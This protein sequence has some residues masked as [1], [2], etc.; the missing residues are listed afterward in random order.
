MT[1]PAGP[2]TPGRALPT[3]AAGFSS[4][5]F[6]IS[7]HSTLSIS[8]RGKN[9]MRHR[10]LWCA[11]LLGVLLVAGLLSCG[12]GEKTAD[13]QQTDQTST[14]GGKAAGGQGAAG[15]QAGAITAENA[16]FAPAIT[17]KG[18]RIVQ[19]RRF[20]SQVDARR[21]SVVVYRAADGSRGGV[22]YVRSFGGE[23]PQPVWHWFF[24]DGAPDSVQ[25]ADINHDGLW[26]VRVFMSGG[27][28]VDYLQDEAFTF[29]GRERDGL[30]AMNGESSA[31]TDMWKAFDADT[32]TAWQS[33]APGAF[34]EVPNP[35]GLETGE[36]S[37]QLSGRDRPKKVA[38][39]AGDRKAQEF[40]L[41]ATE[42]EQRF[43]LDPSLRSAE[44]I[45]VVL[46]G[47][48]GSVAISEME[49]R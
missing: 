41:A 34:L 47:A 36:L 8:N 13:T 23:S 20:P 26:D 31:P 14:A 40:D 39:F 16:P 27:T 33:P 11:E 38:L 1:L 7:F 17:G 46:E 5:R 22:L 44:S 43:L 19:A 25:A 29:M 24:R 6:Q 2:L 12:K 3:I 15:R 4:G 21:A 42:E 35:F 10:S 28:S 37:V 9:A 45:R 18:Y 48:G 30:V 49:I 32:S